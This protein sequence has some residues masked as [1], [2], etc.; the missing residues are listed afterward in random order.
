MLA[1]KYN[2]IDTFLNGISAENI[3]KSLKE[4][5]QLSINARTVVRV[6]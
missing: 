6:H 5:F 2:I 3:S 4:D 1:I